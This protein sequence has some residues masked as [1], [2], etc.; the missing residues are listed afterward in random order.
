RPSLARYEP[1]DHL[2]AAAGRRMTRRCLVTG[3]AGV[4]GSHLVDRL[5]AE[6]WAVTV[7]DDFSTGHRANL[8]HAQRGGGVRVLNGSIL[9]LRAVEEAIAG[10]SDYS[11]SLCNAC[12]ARSARLSRTMTSM[13]P[14][15]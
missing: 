12:A 10:A 2:R 13:Q 6:G 14:G 15:R 5:V 3:G 1:A 11:I 8:V 9:D 7:L 4:I